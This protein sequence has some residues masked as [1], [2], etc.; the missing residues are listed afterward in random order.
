M[1]YAH[2]MLNALTQSKCSKLC[3][4]NMLEPTP[5]FY[6]ISANRLSQGCPKIQ[7]PYPSLAVLSEQGQKNAQIFNHSRPNDLH[8]KAKPRLKPKAHS[9]GSILEHS[10]QPVEREP[11]MRPLEAEFTEEKNQID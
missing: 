9:D 2:I 11:R 8:P 6:C 5:I 4:P 7:S 1:V 3:W 10:A